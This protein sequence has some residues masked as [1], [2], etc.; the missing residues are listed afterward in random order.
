M[1]NW[2]SGSGVNAS[3]EELYNPAYWVAESLQ[4]LKKNLVVSNL[5]WRDPNGSGAVEYGDTVTFSKPQIP[6]VEESSAGIDTTLTTK[7]LRADKVTATIKTYNYV[8]I[9]ITDWENQR[10]FVDIYQRHIGPAL[11]SLANQIDYN[12]LSTMAEAA[13]AGG[14][15]SA[16]QGTS[17]AF[18]FKDLARADRYL[19]EKGVPTSP[20]YGVMSALAKEE[21]F[22]SKP[23]IMQSKA[24]SAQGDAVLRRG[25][26]GTYH[27][28]NWFM[29]QQV[30]EAYS[31]GYAYNL[32][33]HPMSTALIM[34]PIV[35]PPKG[36]GARVSSTSYDGLAIRSSIAYSESTNTL[37]AK[38]DCL[39]GIVVLNSRMIHAI[40]TA[41]NY[42]WG[43]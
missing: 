7:D 35:V 29:T 21:L 42:H 4:W 31:S 27:G 14:Y 38:L 30:P 41:D 11:Y 26:I 8:R 23:E 36:T 5:I 22:N 43:S 39:Y 40:T 19:N 18:D 33:F 16:G 20:R 24:A 3:F 25:E 10:S 12:V 32:A 28:I 2:G 13:Q 17:S 37:Y 6:A 9:T 1:V 15:T 34:R